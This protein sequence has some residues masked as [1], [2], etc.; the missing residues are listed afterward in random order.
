MNLTFYIH[1]TH[2]RRCL[3]VRGAEAPPKF[4]GYNFYNFFFILLAKTMLPTTE[5]DLRCSKTGV[6]GGGGDNER[7]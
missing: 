5:P 7:E 4:S 2:R 1:H 3:R 6:V